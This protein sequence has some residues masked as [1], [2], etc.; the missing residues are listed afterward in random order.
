MSD[1]LS[2]RRRGPASKTELAEIDAVIEAQRLHRRNS[3]TAVLADFADIPSSE[4][5]PEWERQ[6]DSGLTSLWEEFTDPL[7]HEISP[8]LAA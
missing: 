4:T 1:K 3:G 7:A 6:R 2:P 5:P 8:A